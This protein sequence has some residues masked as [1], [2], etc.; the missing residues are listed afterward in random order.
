M[1]SRA[2]TLC[3]KWKLDEMQAVKSKK[4]IQKTHAGSGCQSQQTL[5]LQ[6]HFPVQPKMFHRGLFLHPAPA[7]S[8]QSLGDKGPH[9][10]PPSELCGRLLRWCEL[11]GTPRNTFGRRN[12]P[13]RWDSSA[14]SAHFLGNLSCVF[15]RSYTLL[16]LHSVIVFSFASHG[17][18]GTKVP[19]WQTL[20]GLRAP[21]SLHVPCPALRGLPHHGHSPRHPFSPPRA[22]SPCAGVPA[23]PC[24][25]THGPASQPVPVPRAGGCPAPGWGWDRPWPLL[26]EAPPAPGWPPRGPTIPRGVLAGAP[27]P[28]LRHCPRQ[29]SSVSA[30]CTA[31]Q[32]KGKWHRPFPLPS[33]ASA[34][35]H[36]HWST[37]RL[38]GQPLSSTDF[39]LFAPPALKILHCTPQ[40]EKQHYQ[41]IE[42]SCHCP[43]ISF[44]E[45]RK[46][47]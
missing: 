31:S 39:L 27:S 45:L 16:T 1:R 32:H 36:P 25:P 47:H 26:Q 9:A 19:L 8:P 20:S 43:K 37:R 7:L 5:T 24:W 14:A 44:Y 40:R 35:R 34:T 15:W 10:H 3:P 17:S 13:V 11:G 6:K 23:L 33:N 12:W 42:T 29:A 28:A 38:K 18:A 41:H 30:H 21:M 4:V 2:P 22:V 46:F